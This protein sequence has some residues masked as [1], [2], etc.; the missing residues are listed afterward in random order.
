MTT[1]S[2]IPFPNARQTASSAARLAERVHAL[3][4]DSFNVRM[5]E[6]H[7]RESMT[8][9]G[10]DMRSVLEVLRTGRAVGSPEL[11]EYGDWRIR[12]RRKVAGRR[13]HVVVAVCADHVE[14]ITT[15]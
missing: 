15:W 13:V 6:P 5:G 11:D 9:R 7:F 2:L 1:A 14:C 3:A 8:K 12:M 4:A 10:I